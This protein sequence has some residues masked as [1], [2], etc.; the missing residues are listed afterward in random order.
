MSV[1]PAFESFVQDTEAVISL[2]GLVVA[3]I[4][5]F[6]SA[7]QKES[8][9]VRTVSALLA[10]AGFGVGVT[11]IWAQHNS[12][13]DAKK[14]SSEFE[15]SWKDATKQLTETKAIVSLAAVN[16]S[17]LAKLN[18]VSPSTRYQ[19]RLSV[20]GRKKEPCLTEARVMR[21]FP[22]GLATGNVRLVYRAGWR[23][24]WCL[25]LGKDLSLASAEIFQRLAAAHSLG[26]GFPPIEQEQHEV[27]KDCSDEWAKEA[28]AVR[29]N[30]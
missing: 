11:G 16:L 14:K 26:S 5:A 9:K 7:M 3:G 29:P 27:G 25:L 6:I 1:Q 4:V 8:T 20:D 18:D 21:L 24:P 10:I 23:Q 12:S 30:R 15:A 13:M 28:V 19:V 2:F 17:D 22:Q